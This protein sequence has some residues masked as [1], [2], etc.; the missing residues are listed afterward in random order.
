MTISN[1]SKLVAALG[2]WR[3]NGFELV[4]IGDDFIQLKFKGTIIGCYNQTKVTVETLQH[5]CCEYWNEQLQKFTG[6]K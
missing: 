2:S 3:D 5:D 6:E 1:E 4:E